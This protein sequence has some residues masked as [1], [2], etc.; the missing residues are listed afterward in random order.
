MPSRSSRP[1]KVL[2][3]ALLA[4]AL[5]AL[6]L[7]PSLAAD[8]GY[9]R[10][11]A[12]AVAR[13]LG[14]VRFFHPS[15]EAAKAK[16]ADWNRHAAAGMLAVALSDDRRRTPEARAR[17]LATW[18]QPLAPTVQVFA[19]SEPRPPL[20]PALVRP[21]EANDQGPLRRVAWRHLG[22]ALDAKLPQWSSDRIDDSAPPGMGNLAQKFDAAPFRGKTLTIR[23]RLHPKSV[24][25]SGAQIWLHV[26]RPV[27]TASPADS[28]RRGLFREKEWQTQEISVAVDPDA[29]SIGFGVAWIGG[30]SLRLDEVEVFAADRRLPGAGPENPSFEL[31][32]S[33]L[34]PL[35][36]I[37]PYE[38]LRAGYRL[39]LVRDGNCVRGACAEIVADAAATPTLPDPSQP[40]EVD[41]GGG[42]RAAIPLALWADRRGT[43]PHRA[44]GQGSEQV[45]GDATHSLHQSER[46][47]A[48]A[49][50]WGVIQHFHP[51]L[52][53]AETDWAGALGPALDRAAKAASDLELLPVLEE[54]AAKLRDANAWVSHR[55]V[56]ATHRLP[57]EAAW[58]E[59]QI[60][61]TEVSAAETRLRRGDRLLT[62]DGQ[63][64]LE[65]LAGIERRT[66]GATAAARRAEALA[67]AWNGNSGE[68]VR[69]GVER[70]GAEPFEVEIGKTLPLSTV[71]AQEKLFAEVRPRIFYLDLR[72]L[73]DSE[74]EA[75]LPLLAN[76]RGLIFDLR[77]A[78]TTSNRVVA[79][80]IDR[81]SQSSS[82]QIPISL[83]PDR[84]EREWLSTF[85]NVLPKPPK[86]GAKVAFLANERAVG[87]AETLLAIAESQGWE[88]VGANSGGSNGTIN[89]LDLPRGFRIAWTGMRVL[90][91]RGEPI[92]G[93]GIAP[94]IPVRPTLQ[95]LEEGRD[96]VLERAIERLGGAAK[97]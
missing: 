34:Q 28:V 63:P 59:G 47:A 55:D 37:F 3:L 11:G 60:V 91:T 19:A 71:V 45:P 78:P 56:G 46:L 1:F 22:V 27:S 5:F 44:P 33:G 67:I 39:L 10:E 80:L 24:Q 21:T 69:L 23:V 53:E 6:S 57:L 62:F 94:T 70:R 12:L 32:E 84:R 25:G 92:Q 16:S 48:V 7:A 86:L 54:M 41:L 49:L 30:G 75:S 29:L 9:D 61:V 40:L 8:D 43:L 73:R 36:W 85:W 52:D 38:S 14:Y 64:L 2:P 65:K 90:G 93:R 18:I 81:P 68:V 72:R 79:S 89:W 20:D 17:A 74:F 76:A 35:G 97:R 82:W 13:L 58:V 87:Y 88:I 51:T 26:E 96:E 42:V 50:A 4:S 83:L 95:G 15:D 31:G 77:G 66:P